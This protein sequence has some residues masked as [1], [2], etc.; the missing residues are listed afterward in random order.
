MIKFGSHTEL[1]FSVV[2]GIK[3]PVQIGDSIRFESTLVTHVETD[4]PR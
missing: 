1:Y 4:C 2:Q 3:V